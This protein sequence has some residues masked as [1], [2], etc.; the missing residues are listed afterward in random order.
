M[1]LEPEVR[2]LFRKEW[3]QLTRSRGPF[4]TSL[5]L[6]IFFILAIP[7]LIIFS[8]PHGPPSPHDLQQ[9]AKLPAGLRSASPLP[10]VLPLLMVI[11]GLVLPTMSATHTIIS[12]RETRTLELLVALPV[13]VGQILQAKFLAVLLLGCAP[14]LALLCVDAV[15]LFVTHRAPV[16]FVLSLFVL[17]TAALA[18][19]TAASLTIGL[20]ARDYRTANNL[21]GVFIAPW[22]FVCSGVLVAL[23]PSGLGPLVLAGVFAV[24]AAILATVAARTITFE[25]LLR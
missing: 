25:R 13:R 8:F 10:L 23:P 16:G 1:W 2:V 19:G 21:G 12:E 9:L 24:A 17:L 3:A 15:V 11:A 14:P 7:M 5:L 6:P 18:Y 22:I 20:L 4:W